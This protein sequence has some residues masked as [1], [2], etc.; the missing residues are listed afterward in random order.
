M[1]GKLLAG[2]LLAGNQHLVE[3]LT[4]MAEKLVAEQQILVENQPRK[5]HLEQTVSQ[6]G[7]SVKHRLDLHQ[8][9][10]KQDQLE[11]PK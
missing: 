4:L 3:K 2:K 8:I 5:V 9:E 6:L 7:L 1:A 10:Q 11:P